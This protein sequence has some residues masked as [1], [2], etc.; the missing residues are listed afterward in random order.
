MREYVYFQNDVCFIADDENGDY[1]DCIDIDVKPGV[2]KVI[3]GDYYDFFLKLSKKV[4]PDVKELHI[5]EHAGVISISNEMFPNVRKV[6]SEK[7][8]YREGSML[9]GGLH[10]DFSLYNT[11]CLKPDETADL[12]GISAILDFAFSGSETLNVIGSDGINTYNSAAFNNSAIGRLPF[13]NGVKC[14]N[15][16]VFDVDTE[17]DNVV[18]PDE[19]ED[20]HAIANHLP[21]EKIKQITVHRGSTVQL[22]YRCNMLPKTVNICGSLGESICQTKEE[23][24][25]RLTI[26]SIVELCGREKVE[27]INIFDD[28]KTYKS[29]DGIVYSYDGKRLLKCPRGKIGHV[30]IPEGTEVIAANAFIIPVNAE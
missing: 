2:E 19:D 29:I 9:C 4:F 1:G 14:I 16:M 11:F 24:A 15:G 8:F 20:L 23:M 18:F 3:F 26:D 27:N 12:S 17:C 25:S 6:T 22:L 10:G 5:S 7:D 30:A 21:F 28:S 13:V